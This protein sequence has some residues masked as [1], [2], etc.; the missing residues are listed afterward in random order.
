[1][2]NS[3][4]HAADLPASAL[5]VQAGDPYFDLPCGDLVDPRGA[6]A[7]L[8]L[9]KRPRHPLAAAALAGSKHPVI[10]DQPCHSRKHLGVSCVAQDG[11]DARLGGGLGVATGG[12]AATHRPPRAGNTVGYTKP[13]G[14]ARVTLGLEHLEIGDHEAAHAAPR[15]SPTDRNTTD[16][17]SALDSSAESIDCPPRCCCSQASTSEAR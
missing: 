4:E 5:C 10:G 11:L 7:G 9:P 6:E 15:A 13:V 16:P 3:A 17:A 2:N 12:I 14:P 8:D 1:M